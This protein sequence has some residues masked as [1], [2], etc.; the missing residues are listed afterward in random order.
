MQLKIWQANKVIQADPLPRATD[1]PRW[2]SQ[3]NNFDM[4]TKSHIEITEAIFREAMECRMCFKQGIVEPAF[5]DVAQP[6]W[7]G[8]D[9]STATTK[10]LIVSL[11]P[12]AGRTPEKKHSNVLFRKTLY[13][14]KDGI[15]SLKSLFTFQ[16]EYIPRWGTPSGRFVKF[17]IDGMRLKLDEIALAN[18][19]WCADAKNKWPEAMLS[20]C[21]HLHTSRLIASVNPDVIILSATGTHKYAAQIEHLVPGCKLICTLHYAHRKGKDTEDQEL[22]RIRKEITSMQKKVIPNKPIQPTAFDRR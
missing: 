8:P 7:I 17:Y 15:I 14:Y 13:D 3:S 1:D 4:K 19:A 2:G 21:F 12:G 18:I 10:V 20:Q 5:I 9:Y 22:K 11:N 6:R 16:K